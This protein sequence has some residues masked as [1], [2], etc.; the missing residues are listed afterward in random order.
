VKRAIAVMHIK[1]LDSI[2]ASLWG[3]PECSADLIGI[4]AEELDTCGHG[5][6]KLDVCGRCSR[7]GYQI[8]WQP[9]RNWSISRPAQSENVQVFARARAMIVWDK[10]GTGLAGV[11]A[12]PADA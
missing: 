12:G 9:A 10:N 3:L 2:F 11:F 7:Y 8:R 6:L 1:I 4:D 5:C